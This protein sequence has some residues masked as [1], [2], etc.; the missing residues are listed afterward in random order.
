[1]LALLGLRIR[2]LHY[3]V[4]Y[5]AQADSKKSAGSRYAMMRKQSKVNLLMLSE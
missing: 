5:S 1:M 3:E 2:Q 4:L